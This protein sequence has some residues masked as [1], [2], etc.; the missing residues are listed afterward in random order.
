MLAIVHE[1]VVE[2]ARNNNIDEVQ[3]NKRWVN[4]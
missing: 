1:N 2:P 4:G 3:K